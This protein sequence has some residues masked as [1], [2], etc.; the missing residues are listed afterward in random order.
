MVDTR[1][2]LKFSFRNQDSCV[3]SS[4]G[5]MVEEEGRVNGVIEV[6]FYT[7]LGCPM[8]NDPSTF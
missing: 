8:W 1:Y 5:S 7:K 2:Y 6:S 4:T 3:E